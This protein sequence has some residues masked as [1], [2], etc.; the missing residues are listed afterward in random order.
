[1]GQIYLLRDHLEKARAYAAKRRAPQP[2]EL[3]ERYEGTAALLAGE[4]PAIVQV[5]RADDIANLLRLSDEFGFKAILAYGYEAHLAGART[6]AA[7]CSGHREPHQG[8]LV[9]TGEGHIRTDEC[10]ESAG[11][12]RPGR[13]PGG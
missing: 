9:S 1:M 13:V 10:G 5:Y 11:G 3:D 6:G 12:R 7:P 2:A 4:I 8:P